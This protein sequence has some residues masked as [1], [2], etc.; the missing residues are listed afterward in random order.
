M[1]FANFEEFMRALDRLHEQSVKLSRSI[2]KD[3]EMATGRSRAAGMPAGKDLVAWTARLDNDS[4]KLLRISR[5]K[6]RVLESH[7]KAIAGKKSRGA[8]KRR[9]K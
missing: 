3:R 2:K 6:E 1:D 5:A 7:R 4:E 8:S 9:S